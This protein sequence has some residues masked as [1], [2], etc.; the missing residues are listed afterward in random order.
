[1]L[2]S[3]TSSRAVDVET[4]FGIDR[5]SRRLVNPAVTLG[6]FDGLHLGHQKIF[7]RVKAEALR[8]GGEAVA[9]TFEPHPLKVLSPQS[10]PPLLTPLR[11]KIS[12]FEQLGIDVV[13]CIEFTKTFSEIS[14]SDFVKNIL[15]EKVG[16]RKVIVGY[17]FHFGKKKKGN[18]QI[19]KQIGSQ[20]NLQVEI[21][22]SLIIDGTTVSSSKIRELIKNG[23]VEKA[24]KLLGR[25][26]SV[27]GKIIEG[28]KRGGRLLGFPTA[29]LEISRELHPLTGVYAVEVLWKGQ[30]FKGVANVG[31][32]PTF[33]T[34]GEGKISTEVYILDFDEDIYGEE[35]QV[36][37]VRRIR[38]EARFDSVPQ[39]ITQIQKDVEWAQE[40]VFK[41]KAPS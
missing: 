3:D 16:A 40:N 7:D 2:P 9:I 15:V 33:Q 31:S 17:N 39:L 1:M 36:D 13:L 24:S 20:F 8:M 29:N 23:Q 34:E 19:L 5:L 4:I 21:V 32:N 28:A 41:T 26:Y 30:S 6:N 37:F 11:K 22:D 27:Q 25:H 18:P 14:P 10:C 38:D 12:L 35:I